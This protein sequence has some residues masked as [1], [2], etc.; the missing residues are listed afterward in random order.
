[1]SR[2]RF[3]VDHDFI[4]DIVKGSLRIEPT[5]E[6]LLARH[7]HLAQVPDLEILNYAAR[8]GWLV[9]SHDVNTMTASAVNLITQG[10]PM[11]GLLIAKQRAP[12]AR[13]I[14]SLVLIWAASEADEYVNRIRFLPL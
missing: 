8:E 12:I 14:D 9:L 10:L 1:V 5:I 3:L 11:N 7:A 13:V 6:F 4:E 2:P